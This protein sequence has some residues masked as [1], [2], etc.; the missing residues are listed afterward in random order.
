MG[1]KPDYGIDSPHI[2]GGLAIFGVLVLIAAFLLWRIWAHSLAIFA[3]LFGAYFLYS[4]AGMLYYS[5]VGKFGSREQLL[6]RIPWQ[7]SE[8]VLDVGCGRGLVLNA[9]A[10]RLTTGEA[11]GVD[12]WQEH[13]V[14]GNRREAVLEN[15]RREGVLDRVKV[16]ESDAR[17]LPFG[18]ASFDVVVSNFVLHEL[19]TAPDREK[20]VRE[21]VRVL[22][23]GGHLA[24]VD[25]IFTNECVHVLQA[26]GI[27]DARRERPD[28]FGARI[29][30]IISLGMTQL[31]CVTGSKPISS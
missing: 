22:K 7:G 25:F 31:Y 15:A 20:M 4:A 23:P 12:V 2:V 26:C 14:S 11:V 27:A 1:Q 18:D 5:K 21:I 10:R 3:L 17:Q 19:K 29:T 8:R 6:D 9:A 28:R 13:A 16:Q 30:A 24:L